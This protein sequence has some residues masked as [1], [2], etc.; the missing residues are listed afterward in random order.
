MVLRMFTILAERLY[1]LMDVQAVD[2]GF[3]G[4]SK[5]N[6]VYIEWRARLIEV[7]SKLCGVHNTKTDPHSSKSVSLGERT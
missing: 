5:R 2:I 1:N 7:V 4:G 6:G 3:L